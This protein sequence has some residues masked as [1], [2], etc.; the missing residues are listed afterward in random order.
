MHF[1]ALFLILILAIC[2][3]AQSGRIIPAEASNPPGTP[4]VQE[5]SVKQ[6]FNEAN[7]YIRKKGS[8]FDAKKIPFNERLFAQAKL[9]QRLLAAK[10][11]ATAAIRKDIVGEDFY[12]LGMLHWIAENLDGTSENLRKFI[13]TENAAADRSQTARSIIVVIAAKQKK[14][15]DAEKMLAEYLAS[16][17]RTAPFNKWIDLRQINLDRQVRAILE[18][19]PHAAKFLLDDPAAEYA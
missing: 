6:M 17:L 14:L 10:F 4:A 9:E 19:S 5:Q 3:P 11:A 13:T 8:E 12:Y 2:A 18:A 7:G 1:F 15:D 16:W